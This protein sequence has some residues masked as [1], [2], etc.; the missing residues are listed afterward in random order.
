MAIYRPPKARWPLALAV[1]ITTLVIG[2]GIGLSIGTRDPSPSEISEML[3]SDLISAA[4]SL[5]VAEVEYRESVAAGEVT[6]ETE[7]EG[8]LA[9]LESSRERFESLEPALES[10][11]PSRSEDI[12]AEYDGCDSAMRSR[13]PASDV[14]TCLE[15]LR[16]LLQGEGT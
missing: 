15:E 13:A 16:D 9:A 12:A 4:G 6:N 11:F 2:V 3:K 7:Y 1:G 10:L 14:A 5:E 8:A